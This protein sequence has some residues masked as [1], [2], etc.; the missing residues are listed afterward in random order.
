MRYVQPV[1]KLKIRHSRGVVLADK[2]G[3]GP[4]AAANAFGNGTSEL[5]RRLPQDLSG[6]AIVARHGVAQDF[7]LVCLFLQGEGRRG[8]GGE[9]SE[10]IEGRTTRNESSQDKECYT[11]S[12]VGLKSEGWMTAGFGTLA[13]T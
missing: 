11:D 3:A 6:V 7:F 8:Q 10:T 2:V 13:V 1:Q 4:G 12:L 9:K 5:L